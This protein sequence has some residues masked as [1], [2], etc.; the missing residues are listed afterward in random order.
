MLKNSCKAINNRPLLCFEAK[1]Y[2]IVE[3]SFLNRKFLM[4]TTNGSRAWYSVSVSLYNKIVHCQRVIEISPLQQTIRALLL[5]NQKS[6]SQFTSSAC[7]NRDSFGKENIFFLFFIHSIGYILFYLN[8]M[9]CYCRISFFLNK[10]CL[11]KE[12]L[13]VLLFSTLSCIYF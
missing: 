4:N 7:D 6:Y 3:F 10:K 13:H 8:V 11:F 1:S 9:I 5:K 12:S 2:I